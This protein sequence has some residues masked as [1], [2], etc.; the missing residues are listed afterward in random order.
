MWQRVVDVV[1]LCFMLNFFPSFFQDNLLIYNSG[2]TCALSVP[3][4]DERG[5]LTLRRASNH[6][7][8][9]IYSYVDPSSEFMSPTPLWY[10]VGGEKDNPL[11]YNL[12]P[13]GK[14]T[15]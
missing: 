15:S 1:N 2:Q 10:Q 13:V 8:F 14:A 5:G 7:N 3:T 11:T 9:V 12:M 6:H 4:L